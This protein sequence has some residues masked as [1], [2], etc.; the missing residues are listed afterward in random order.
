MEREVD[1]VFKYGDAMLKV[2]RGAECDK[3]YFYELD[4]LCSSVKR[5]RGECAG[6]KRDDDKEIVFKQVNDIEK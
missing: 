5:I 2:V 1:S 4:C 6:N 3:C